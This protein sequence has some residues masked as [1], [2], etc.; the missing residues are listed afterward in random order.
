[1]V[2]AH[3]RESAYLR[4]MTFES[5]FHFAKSQCK[6]YRSHLHHITS[7]VTGQRQRRSL[8]QVCSNRAITR[9]QRAVNRQP[10]SNVNIMVN[11]KG[12][13]RDNGL[14]IEGQAY[15]TNETESNTES[16]H[17][18]QQQHEF[19]YIDIKTG[20]RIRLQPCILY[21]DEPSFRIG[22]I[23]PRNRQIFCPYCFNKEHI[24][25]QCALM[26]H[27]LDFVL[28][29][30]ECLRADKKAKVS[31]TLY[32]NAKAYLVVNKSNIEK[33]EFK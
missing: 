28:K 17:K 4:E 6:A 18:P 30:Y 12:T 11:D 9:Q 31:E 5:L 32:K 23:D 19:F 21:E 29:N 24:Y 14:I 25:P 33:R 8:I 1:M 3:H 26:L 27:Q 20:Q 16:D 7:I 22:W 2:V 10:T 15:Q 13:E